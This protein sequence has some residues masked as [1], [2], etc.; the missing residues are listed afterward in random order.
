MSPW[1][2]EMNCLRPLRS[3]QSSPAGVAV[4][5]T[6]PTSDPACGSVIATA[7]MSPPL[8][9]IGRYRAFCCSVPKRKMSAAGEF[10]PM[11]CCTWV[12]RSARASISASIIVTV[13]GSP[14][15]PNSAGTDGDASPSSA[16]PRRFS[17]MGSFIRTVPFSRMTPISSTSAARGAISLAM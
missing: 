1:P 4:V 7:P 6:L 16:S 12:A 9:R 3:Q 15:P 10:H 13:N 14:A 8:A 2:A 17:V 11:P 5:E